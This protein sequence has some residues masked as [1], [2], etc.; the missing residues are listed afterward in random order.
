MIIFP[1]KIPHE[2]HDKN[3][4]SFP[5]QE[6]VHYF[7]NHLKKCKCQHFVGFQLARAAPILCFKPAVNRQPGLRRWD[8]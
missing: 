3:V 2:L 1:N 4:H 7:E 8:S 6:R 5:R